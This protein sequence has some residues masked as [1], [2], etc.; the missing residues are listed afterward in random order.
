MASAHDS[1][2]ATDPDPDG[3]GGAAVDT[4][5]TGAAGNLR[6]A[7]SANWN[8]N[9][10]IASGRTFINGAGTVVII[11]S[12]T[13]AAAGR[14][15]IGDTSSSNA[16]LRVTGGSLDVSGDVQRIDVGNVGRGTFEM[17][18]GTV[19]VFGN[20]YE[21]VSNG[22]ANAQGTINIVGGSLQ[23][24]GRIVMGVGTGL[25]L[26]QTLNMAAGTLSAGALFVADNEFDHAIVNMTGGSMVLGTLAIPTN[27]GE[28][29]LNGHFQLDGGTVTVTANSTGGTQNL[30]S[31]FRLANGPPNPPLDPADVVQGTMDITGG[32]LKLAGD[33]TPLVQSYV[34][35]GVLTGFGNPEFV[36]YDYNVT[37]PGYTT[38]TAHMPTVSEHVTTNIAASMHNVNSTVY[39]RSE[40]NVASV[41]SIDT[42]SLHVQYNDGFVAYL[43]GQEVARRN[44]P[45]SVA[46]N[47]AATASAG[48]VAEEAI[49]ISAY[50]SALHP[51]ADNVLAIQGLNLSA[52]DA[53]F[54]I[55]PELTAILIP[56]TPPDVV[57]NEI[58]AATPSGFW[59]EIVNQGTS[60]VSLEGFSIETSAGTG[61]AYVFGNQPIAA[62]QSMLVSQAV[63]G[64]GA[65]DGDKLYFFTADKDALLD[66][67]VVTTQVRGLAA[68]HGEDW[69]YPNVATPGAANSFVFHDE[70]VINEIMYHQAPQQA[71]FVESDEEW[72]ELYNHSAAPVN[73][74]GWTLRDAIDFDFPST[75]SYRRADTWSSPSTPRRYR[76]SIRRSRSSAI[77]PARC[78]IPANAS[79]CAGRTRTRPTRSAITTAASG[80][81]WPTAADRVSNCD[82]PTPTI[83]RRKP[84][85]PAMKARRASGRPL[86]SRRPPR[87]TRGRASGM[88]S[89]SDC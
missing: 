69:L 15:L 76:P 5:W 39:V 66:A 48:I 7:T 12:T 60:P 89:C 67:R 64:F 35:A 52:A 71:P 31:G 37:N 33:V 84:G 13:T 25:P 81:S 58:A 62:G 27:Y 73:L 34:T 17:L 26:T 43:N 79:C 4:T 72:I 85:R 82:R 20:V 46:W 8:N 68:G 28:P 56:A 29:G 36:V 38:V 49:D 40:F 74:T 41:A 10:P 83:R 63:L 78:R 22:A 24:D 53:T 32:T 57:F 54:L 1:G 9:V 47:S 59:L 87:P 42:L 55:L 2:D 14:V 50:V 61:S 19:H 44:A 75:R 65:A 88:N 18:G 21:G 77:T 6:W 3:G 30:P 16:T 80:R 23:V 70:I 86:L 45:L 51:G 11:D